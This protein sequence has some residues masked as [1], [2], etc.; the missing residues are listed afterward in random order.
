MAEPLRS[1]L[2]V[3][4]DPSIAQ[5]VAM[6]L[7]EDPVHLITAP[8][9]REARALLQKHRYDVLLC[10]LMLTDGSGLDLLRELGTR[11]GLRR[12]A[13]SAG[14]SGG[15]LTQLDQAGGAMAQQQPELAELKCA[16]GHWLIEHVTTRAVQ[17][18]CLC[19]C[20]DFVPLNEVGRMDIGEARAAF[21]RLLGTEPERWLDAGTRELF[22]KPPVGVTMDAIEAMARCLAGFAKA[23][24]TG[25]ASS[26]T[27]HHGA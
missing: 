21:I 26:E 7:E 16:C 20:L 23:S 24:A 8:T 9:L 18:C 25:S 6:A 11:A 5:F 2:L 22:R 12:V 1:V 14:I 27:D 15:M 10:D 3:E 19:S 4:D 13:F 17:E